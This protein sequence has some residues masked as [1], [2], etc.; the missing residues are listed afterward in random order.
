[1]PLS[2]EERVR[3]E[4]LER[5]LSADDPQLARKLR[6]GLVQ[7]IPVSGSV[8]H[9]LAVMAAIGL[10]IL[11]LVHLVTGNGLLGAFVITLGSYWLFRLRGTPANSGQ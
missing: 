3:L 6:F 4:K 10:L 9:G 11:G 1:M 2:D 7:G 8:M 5:E